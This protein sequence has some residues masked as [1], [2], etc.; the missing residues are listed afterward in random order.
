MVAATIALKISTM[1]YSLWN[2]KNVKYGPSR[3]VKENQLT[4]GRKYLFIQCWC[5]SE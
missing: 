1:R 4:N 2:Y 5:S 3:N